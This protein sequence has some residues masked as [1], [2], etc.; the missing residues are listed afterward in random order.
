[1]PM[2]CVDG[3]FDGVERVGPADEAFN[4][5]SCRALKQRDCGLQRPVGRLAV[6]GVG[7]QQRERAR[8]APRAALDFLEEPRRGDRSVRNDKDP[9]GR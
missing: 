2:S 5:A 6:G 4:L 8:A 1:M 3:A 7:D 9:C